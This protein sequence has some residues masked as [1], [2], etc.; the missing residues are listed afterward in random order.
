MAH[1]QAPMGANLFWLTSHGYPDGVTLEDSKQ[2]S[3]EEMTPLSVDEESFAMY[4]N[5]PFY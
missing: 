5:H 4:V 2:P 1:N 3:A